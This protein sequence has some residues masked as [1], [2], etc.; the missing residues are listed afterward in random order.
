M[1]LSDAKLSKMLF[2]PNVIVVQTTRYK[3]THVSTLMQDIKIMNTDNT[4]YCNTVFHIYFSYV[5]FTY[6]NIIVKIHSGN[7]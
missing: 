6:A 2:V 5:P 4:T 3:C 1:Y 7:S